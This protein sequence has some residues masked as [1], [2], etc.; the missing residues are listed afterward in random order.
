MSEKKCN[1]VG[2][3]ENTRREQK[4]TSFLGTLYKR[5]S[6]KERRVEKP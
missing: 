1:K 3:K 2:K 4:G 6:R 5:G